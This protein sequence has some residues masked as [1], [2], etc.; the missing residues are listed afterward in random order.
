[1]LRPQLG[2]GGFRRWA[3]LTPPEILNDLTRADETRAQAADLHTLSRIVDGKYRG[4]RASVDLTAVAVALWTDPPSSLG[5]SRELIGPGRRPFARP[6][7]V[8]ARGDQ[9][10]RN[11]DP[12]GDLSRSTRRG[13]L[14]EAQP[15][16]PTPYPQRSRRASAESLRKLG[17]GGR[18]GIATVRRDGFRR[19]KDEAKDG[20]K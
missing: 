3:L 9:P 5:W 10:T 4:L 12:A 11:Q 15:S 18:P 17:S 20:K 8:A 13:H 19:P 2:H 14:R 7:R 6:G 1:M 16:C